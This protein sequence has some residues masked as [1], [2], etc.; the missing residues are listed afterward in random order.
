MP[1]KEQAGVCPATCLQLQP[2]MCPFETLHT[3]C[4]GAAPE[5]SMA[6]LPHGN[7][8]LEHPALLSLPTPRKAMAWGSHTC[9]CRASI[10]TSQACY[11]LSRKELNRMEE[12]KWLRC[13]L[14]S[15]PRSCIPCELRGPTTKPALGRGS[16]VSAAALGSPL[17]LWH[18]PSLQ[19]GSC[20]VILQRE[21]G[22]A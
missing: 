11:Q 15:R 1:S 21:R 5:H 7:I 17:P 12:R 4:P 13:L 2:P 8:H 9:P 14:C 10:P 18:F 19:T 16:K 3:V 22:R 6:S 20:I